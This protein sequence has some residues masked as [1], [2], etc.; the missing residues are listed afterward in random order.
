MKRQFAQFLAR[1]V[2][3]TTGIMIAAHFLP[4]VSYQNEWYVLVIS[5]LILSIINVLIKP[6][7]IILALPAL[8]VT[9]GI[10]SIII[11]GFMVYL[12]HLI[13][14]PFQISGFWTAVLAGLIV[15]LVNYILTWAFDIATPR[16]ER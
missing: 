4:G 11:N 13:Y 12:A 6:F 5:A 2:L 8:I 3:N 9:L 15:G 14:P 7:I 10:F 16:E 1:W